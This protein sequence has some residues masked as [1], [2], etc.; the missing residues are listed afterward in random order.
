MIRRPPR[1]TLFPYTTL[2]RSPGA[3]RGGRST[4]D[5]EK[6]PFC[7]GHEHMSPPEVVAYRKDG[8]PNGPGW[9]IRCVPNKYPALQVEGEVHR[10][11]SQLFHS[12]NGVGA[13]EVIVET[14]EHEHHLSM[15]SE[16]QVQEII[17]AYKQRYLD[18]IRDKRFKYILIFKNH[19]ERAG[20]SISHPHS[21]LIATPIVPRRIVEEVNS[22]NRFYESTG[23]SCLYCEIVETELEE[24][25][26]IVSENESFV[27]L[28]PYAARF[29]FES[30]ILPKRVKLSDKPY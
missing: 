19:G 26:R 15:Q 12:V 21:Q 11:V 23:G 27:C 13:H 25:K 2:F 7:Y 16:F 10:H 3:F 30:W 22:L 9:W 20:A 18:L 29:P 24:E 6:C 8:V 14:P 5:P 4:T 1:S 28:S 17:T